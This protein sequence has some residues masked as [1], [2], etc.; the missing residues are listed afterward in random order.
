MA[1]DL[2]D[3]I[4]PADVGMRHLTRCPD[5][6]VELCEPDGIAGHRVRQKL[7]RHRLTEPQVVRAI[8]LAHSAAAEQADDAIAAIEHCAWS[9][10]SVA[11]RIRRCEPAA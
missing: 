6:V 10:T 11:D 8:H 5:F 2:T 7:E 4:D 9:E 3:V 1:L